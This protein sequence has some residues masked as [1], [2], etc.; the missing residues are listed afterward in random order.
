MEHSGSDE[1]HRA[2][3]LMRSRFRDKEEFVRTSTV[4]RVK[5]SASY[6]FIEVDVCWQGFIDKY[7]T[8]RPKRTSSKL[9]KII[10]RSDFLLVLSPSYV[11]WKDKA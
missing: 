11:F 3:L 9:A 2:S 8:I 5:N 7:R 10:Y 6:Y 1:F 4:Q